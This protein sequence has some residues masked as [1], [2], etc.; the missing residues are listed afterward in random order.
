MNCN[1]TKKLMSAY[2][3]N[4]LTGMEMLAIRR[5]T[6]VC[7]ECELELEAF[8]STKESLS[9]LKNVTPKVD[10][11]NI[12]LSRLD[13]ESS[14]FQQRM[15]VYISSHC[16][17]KHMKTAFVSLAACGVALLAVNINEIGNNSFSTESNMV[18]SNDILITASHYNIPEANNSFVSYENKPLRLANDNFINISDVIMR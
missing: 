1:R 4:E 6:S 13:N 3:D 17:R 14:S 5:H 10:I 9:R 7:K 12:I 11:L 18:A 15:W 2:I 8:L 16:A